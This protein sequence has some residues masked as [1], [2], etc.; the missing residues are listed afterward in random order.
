LVEFGAPCKTGQRNQGRV[1]LITPGFGDEEGKTGASVDRATAILRAS[2]L[3]Q[4][5]FEIMA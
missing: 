1:A 2:G 5:E 3:F 4:T